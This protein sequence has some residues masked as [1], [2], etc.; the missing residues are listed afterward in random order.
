M[1]QVKEKF[2]NVVTKYYVR[3]LFRNNCTIRIS[4]EETLD[5]QHSNGG[6]SMTELQVWYSKLVMRPR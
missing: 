1:L 4:G 5:D 6:K 2:K 3:L